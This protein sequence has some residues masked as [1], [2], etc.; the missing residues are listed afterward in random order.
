MYV[1]LNVPRS[2][3]SVLV[4]GVWPSTV[5]P[6][7]TSTPMNRANTWASGMNSSVRPPGSPKT[8]GTAA[9]ALTVRE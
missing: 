9:T 6:A 1:G 5:P 2:S 4:S 3:S 8:S 7:T